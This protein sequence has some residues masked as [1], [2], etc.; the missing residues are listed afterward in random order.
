MRPGYRHTRFT[1]WLS[2]LW[3]LAANDLPF[4]SKGV[5]RLRSECVL[6]ACSR[7][8][9][10]PSKIRVHASLHFWRARLAFPAA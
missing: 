3:F 7:S 4:N 10:T 1:P 8:L 6:Q 5:G 9:N 2:L